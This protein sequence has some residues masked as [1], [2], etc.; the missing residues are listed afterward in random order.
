MTK[1]LLAT[2]LLAPLA[3]LPCRAAAQAGYW[4]TSGNRILDAAGNPVRLAGINWYGFETSNEV[5]HG[6]WTR[7]YKA[8]FDEIKAMGFNT[9]RIP[10]SNQ[11]LHST[12]IP[13]ISFWSN[14]P[15]N[16][17]LQG[18]TPIQVLDKVIAYCGQIGLKVLLD[19]HRSEDGNSAEANGLWYTAAYSEAAWIADWQ[20]VAT[21]YAGNA[22]VVAMD[23]RNEPHLMVSGGAL[24]ACWGCGG[25][26]DW[27]LAAQKAGNAILAINPSVLIV[28]EG[29]DSF[30]G[31]GTWW[32]GQLRGV[33][34]K[35][36]VL[37]VANR[38][39]YSP[40]DY[41]PTEFQQSWF[42][43]ST[44]QASLE[45]V[46]EANWG[47]IDSQGI[48]PVLVGEFGTP[49]SAS[50][51]ASAAAGS[52]GQWFSALVTFMKKRPTI[53]WTYWALNGNDRYG[54]YDANFSG[55]VL[56][57]KLTL[58]QTIQQPVGP[59][60]PTLTVARAG[61]GVGA[62]TSS[63]GGISC[64]TTCSATYATGAVV[65]LT[66]TATSPSIFGGWSGPCNG[67]AATCTVTMSG[68]QTV[69]ATFIG[70]AAATLTVA[71]AGTGAGTVTATG[72]NCGTTCSATYAA[73]T[74][75]TLTATATSPSTF[76]GWSIASC[77]TAPTCVVTVSGAQTVT[78]TFDGASTFPLTV[79]KTGPTTGTVTSTPAGISCG[80]T[81]SASYTAGTVVTLTA[82]AAA[83]STFGGWSGACAGS[84]ATCQVTLS[85]ARSVT[86]N[87]G[88]QVLTVARAGTGAGTVTSSVGG[89][90]CGTVCTSTYGT[91]VTVTL[92]ATPTSPSTFGGWSVAGC[93]T[94]ATCAVTMS[95]SQT[96]TATFN[97]GGSTPCTNPVTFTGNTGNFNAAGAVCYRTAQAVNGWGCS[98]FAGRTVSVNGGAASATCGGGP[99]PLGKASDGYTYFAATAGTYPWASLY[100]W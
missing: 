51:V 10:F 12:T 22:T 38:L 26:T 73:G 28:V 79:T 17:D 52:Q 65:T 54:L 5:L 37:S 34:T 53:N 92:T 33:A 70:D 69:T 44:T 32:G 77:G 100:V 78:A 93:G 9:V 41:G 29:N 11:A 2:A 87:F 39:V 90:S 83:G 7:E 86:A 57:A 97:P 91:G 85:V 20:L 81:C 72:I 95:A 47:Y 61:S 21:R 13:N 4:H 31:S 42:N 94:A 27:V 56:P 62:V 84:A 49:N 88:G 66:A 68:S 36:V 50:D 8:V 80:A 15:I 74:A 48:A 64:G 71:R 3:S 89:I 45:A 98:N 16:T 59:T 55:V 14:G 43:A 1:L 6:L 35:P 82:T 40:H 60:N 99:F 67:T 18:L 19:N 63:T 75:V 25:A 58:L 24:G 96:V 46:W 23:L 30:G 76:A